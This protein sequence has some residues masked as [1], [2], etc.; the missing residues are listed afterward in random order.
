GAVSAGPIS[1]GLAG[2]TAATTLLSKML[3]AGDARYKRNIIAA[4]TPAIPVVIFSGEG[5]DGEY[6]VASNVDVVAGGFGARAWRDGDEVAGFMMSPA[7]RIPNIEHQ[8]QSYPIMYLYRREAVDS[9]GAGRFRGGAGGESAV[10][11]LEGKSISFMLGSHGMAFPAGAGLAGGLPAKSVTYRVLRDADMRTRLPHGDLPGSVEAI[12]GALEW[13]HAK[14]AE[15]E[16]GSRDVFT[17][18]WAGGGGYGDPLERDP[19]AVAHDVRELYVTTKQARHAYGVVLNGDAVDADATRT[20]REELRGTRIGAGPLPEPDA[21]TLPEGA[22]WLDDHLH[23]S[24][25]GAVGCARCGHPLSQPGDSY[26]TGAV[27]REI[28]LVENG[29]AWIDPRHY[30][31]DPVVMREFACPGCG[32]ALASE[33]TRP[34]VAPLDDMVLARSAQHNGLL[35]GLG[36]DG[37]VEEFE[38]ED[39]AVDA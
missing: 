36:D 12:G 13:P 25:T 8:E 19:E 1:G 31:D 2:T 18:N 5:H 15:L 9:G 39:I 34:E 10:I 22:V 29:L 3:S 21:A 24:A 38:L 32:V 20:L 35:D 6:M 23:V 7:C 11:S 27:P 4:S 17:V 37:N 33:V 28:D 30:I 26:K 16:I 14:A